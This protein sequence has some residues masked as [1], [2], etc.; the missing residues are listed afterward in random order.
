MKISSLQKREPFDKV[1]NETFAAF[2]TDYLNT[3]HI[4]KW[5]SKKLLIKP[6]K[7]TQKWYCN[8]LINSI[9]IQGVNSEVFDSINAEYLNNPLKPWRSKLQRLYLFLSQNKL[10]SAILSKYVID[11]S[12][13]LKDAKNKLIIGGNT[14]I[15]FIDVVEK[16]VYVILKKGFDRAYIDKELYA[17]QNFKYLDIPKVY[18]KGNRAAWYSEEY[19]SGA[20]PNRLDHNTGLKALNEVI[21]GIQHMLISTMLEVNLSVYVANIEKSVNERLNKMAHLNNGGN[22]KIFNF[23]EE[24]SRELKGYPDGTVF[25]AYCHGDFHQGN[26]ICDGKKNWVLDW[27]H[28]GQRQIGYDLMILLMDSRIS[29]GFS[30]RFM[31]ILHNE[32][33]SHQRLLINNW[34]NLNWSNSE[35]KKKDLLLFLLEEIDFHV[36]GN[37]NEVF[38]VDNKTFDDL[39]IEWQKCFGSIIHYFN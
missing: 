12:P 7:S 28:S 2:L 4:V 16:R 20:S 9:F 33:T 30:H 22:K 35:I 1:F 21:K 18:L 38:F 3:H 32:L 8:P 17:R 37:N 6:N 11:I 27:E 5:R 25:S 39:L 29:S 19:I 14:K 26:I 31:K 23:L 15:R 36:E 24:L 10:T 34:P 13:P